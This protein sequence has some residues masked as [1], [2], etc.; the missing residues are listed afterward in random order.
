MAVEGKDYSKVLVAIPTR[1]KID[2]NTVLRLNE[3]RDANPGLP[4]IHIAPGRLSVSDV[5]NRIVAQF[6]ESPHDILVMVDDDVVPHRNMLQ[7][8]ETEYDIVGATYLIFRPNINLPFP[9]V[10]RWDEQ[11]QHY[12]PIE[13]VFS[14]T[15]LVPCDAVATGCMAIK[16]AVL[17]N[18]ELKAPFA[19][20]YN[21]KGCMVMSDDVAFCDRA[22]K[23]GYRI[24]ADFSVPCDH[25]VD[26]VSL[27]HLHC[28]YSEAYRVAR[29]KEQSKRVI[30]LG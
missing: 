23:L 2:W 25:M 18:P 29:E 9:A 26:G 12:W 8:T 14:K 24:G 21:E 13:D 27:N 11:K 4:P 22:R 15:T 1:G 19:M 5:R 16:R 10:L 6:L 3:I 7:I 30:T 28:Q 17:E 20:T